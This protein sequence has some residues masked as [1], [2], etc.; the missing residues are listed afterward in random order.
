MQA[1]IT[2]S[3]ISGTDDV[4]TISKQ[5]KKNNSYPTPKHSV[6]VK[7]IKEN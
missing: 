1:S 2:T 3:F 5:Y 6:N 7:P 4:M